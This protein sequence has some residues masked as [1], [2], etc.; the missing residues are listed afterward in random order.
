MT[1]AASRAVPNQRH[2]RVTGF[3]WSQ[4]P[5]PQPLTPSIQTRVWRGGGLHRQWSSPS[6]LQ[7]AS[8]R[9][10]WKMRRA[11]KLCPI[12]VTGRS[13][14]SLAASS[15]ARRCPALTLRSATTIQ[16]WSMSCTSTWCR[17]WTQDPNPNPG[18]TNLKP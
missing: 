8:S 11:P 17:G 3:M 1:E 6:A 12:R 10:Q 9:R 7:R 2:R 13:L 18:H 4:A 14:C 15:K 16:G 5:D